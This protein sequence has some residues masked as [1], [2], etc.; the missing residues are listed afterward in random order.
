MIQ[1][2]LR[3][4]E[5]TVL[6]T[7]PKGD[8]CIFVKDERYPVRSVLTISPLGVSL[9]L[10]NFA[11]NDVAVVLQY[12]HEDINLQVNGTIV[13]KAAVDD[14]DATSSTNRIYRVG[15]NLISPHLLFS[16]MQSE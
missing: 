7:Q 3:K 11:S 10:D 2:E 6:L 1:K 4:A 14:P 8:L 15:I 5:R 13:W 12:R 16:L 9:L